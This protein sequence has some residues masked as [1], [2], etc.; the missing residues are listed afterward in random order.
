MGTLFA[1]GAQAPA[2]ELAYLWPCNLLAWSVWQQV[3]TEWRSS[4]MGATWLDYG[5]VRAYLDEMGYSGQERKDIFAGIRAADSAM[6]EVWVQQ[7]KDR[8]EQQK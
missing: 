2:P 7:A 3:Q 5:G 1:A 4:G 6:R 8:A